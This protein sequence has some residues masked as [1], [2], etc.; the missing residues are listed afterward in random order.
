MCKG[1]VS[2]RDAIK[3]VL[4]TPRKKLRLHIEQPAESDKCGRRFR[5]STEIYQSGVCLGKR[6]ITTKAPVG[7]QLIGLTRA[8]GALAC[9]VPYVDAPDVIRFQLPVNFYRGRGIPR[10][11]NEIYCQNISIALAAIMGLDERL[12]PRPAWD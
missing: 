9:H 8:S 7:N 2:S 12:S 1:W 10:A 5:A 6:S 4:L 11:R 3:S